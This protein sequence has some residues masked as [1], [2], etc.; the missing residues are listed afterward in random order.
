MTGGG[1]AAVL[2]GLAVS[3]S[4]GTAGA[5]G[6]DTGSLAANAQYYEWVIAQTGGASPAGLMSLSATAP[7]MP[8]GYTL[9]ARV[10]GGAITDGSKNFYRIRQVG[11]TAWYVITPATNTSSVPEIASGSNSNVFTSTSVAALVPAT[12]IKGRFMVKILSSDNGSAQLGPNANF[13]ISPAAGNYAPLVADFDMSEVSG[14]GSMVAYGEFPFETAG[15]VYFASSVA[16][17][18]AFLYGWE[19]GF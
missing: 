7:T 4:S 17:G 19:D 18:A 12:A 10:G 6:L 1:A 13:T 2:T 5:G 11:S 8:A 15:V 3:I 9:K 14:A 16:G